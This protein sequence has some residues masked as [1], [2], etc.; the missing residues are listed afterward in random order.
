MSSKF[1][2]YALCSSLFLTIRKI[3]FPVNVDF[4][5]FKQEKG[6]QHVENKIYQ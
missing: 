1:E 2:V 3:V 5:Y 6:E 4:C